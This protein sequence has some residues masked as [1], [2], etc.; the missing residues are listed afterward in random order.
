ML[1]PFESIP[2]PIRAEVKRHFDS[3]THHTGQMEYLQIHGCKV[4][5]SGGERVFS[6]KCQRS[7]ELRFR[8]LLALLLNLQ[9]SASLPESRVKP[10][11]S[12][13]RHSSPILRCLCSTRQ[14]KAG[15][16][17]IPAH[18]FLASVKEKKRF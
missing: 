13:Q 3:F 15:G 18:I 12:Q 8:K 9:D 5:V 1:A 7:A 11:G 14:K 2:I 4:D 6:A 16:F 17:V 10:L